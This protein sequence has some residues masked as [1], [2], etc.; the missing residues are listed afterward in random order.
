M[1]VET[2][3]AKASATG[4]SKCIKSTICLVGKQVLDRST[5]KLLDQVLDSDAV[6]E[7]ANL[8]ILQQTIF[9]LNLSAEEDASLTAFF[10]SEAFQAFVQGLGLQQGFSDAQRFTYKQALTN[11]LVAILP[12]TSIASLQVFSQV[13][14]DIL[15]ERAATAWAAA[16]SLGIVEV[17][18]STSAATASY[19]HDNV[20][21]AQQIIDLKLA[22]SSEEMQSVEDF[23][24]RYKRAV[25]HATSRIRPQAPNESP[26]LPVDDLYVDPSVLLVSDQP[27]TNQS[28]NALITISRRSVLLGNPGGGKS[29]LAAKLC[30]D[31]SSASSATDDS[32]LPKFAALVILRDFAQSQKSR[33]SSIA[34]YIEAHCKSEYQIDPPRN[35]FRLL[36]LS[37]RI[38]IVFDGLDE[39]LE[40]KDRNAVRSAVEHFSIEYPI[41]PILVTSREIGY[42][43]APLDRALFNSFKLTPFAEEQVKQYAEKWFTY[44]CSP[45][46][47]EAKRLSLA[48]LRDSEVVP[49][50]RSNPLMLGLLCNLYKQDGFIPRNRPEVYQRC[51][52]LLFMKWDSGRG[53]YVKLPLD[54]RLRPAMSYLAH[55]I[56]QDETLQAGVTEDKLVEATSSYLSQWIEDED[57]A[58]SISRQ[59]VE[60]FNGRA[61][62]FTD[63]GSDRHQRL[64]Q[65]THRTFLEYFTA[66]RL[67][68][69]F[70]SPEQLYENLIVKIESRDWDVVC[71]L[72]F[73]LKAQKA[74]AHNEFIDLL[75]GRA[76]DAD[77]PKKM[78]ILSFLS[79]TLDLLYPMPAAR[80]KAVRM[81]AETLFSNLG[82]LQDEFTEF[83][84]Q[85]LEIASG[86]MSTSEESLKINSAELSEA[87]ARS[88]EDGAGT[89]VNDMY[90]LMLAED[91]GALYQMAVNEGLQSADRIR[92]WRLQSSQLSSLTEPRTRSM[93]EHSSEMAIFS[94]WAGIFTVR[95]IVQSYGY[96]SLFRAINYP[97]ASWFRTPISRGI[98]DWTISSDVFANEGDL[99]QFIRLKKR[100]FDECK[101]ISDLY[102]VAPSW[103]RNQEDFFALS[104]SHRLQNLQSR[105]KLAWP[106]E[107][108]ACEAFLICMAVISEY[109]GEKLGV[110]KSGEVF[111][112][113]Q[114]FVN[115]RKHS[116]ELR[117]RAREV[118]R[119]RCAHPLVVARLEE[120]V[121]GQKNFLV[122]N[123]I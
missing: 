113:L 24:A 25:V 64:Y 38:L 60:F 77:F 28:S 112:D 14:F 12:N 114:A 121:S 67:V 40:I 89:S 35:A 93:G 97:L 34:D 8:S 102:S 22:A 122:T 3:L 84:P 75:C 105:D 111:D 11:F 19:V 79:R 69:L 91:L 27:A 88:L 59:F 107:A 1:I 56:Y 95:E 47:E 55:W 119:A 57:E 81:C 18:W 36:L 82:K 76:S 65:F 5:R 96:D 100:V 66:D 26:V 30:H 68:M 21:S 104:I 118:V 117:E 71:Q 62:V 43:Q 70:G 50:L 74:E 45:N 58:K 99:E 39:L 41:A 54:H 98:T 103:P 120:W 86:I 52:D 44:A 94:W 13:I 80:R 87:L 9:A 29:T 2:A 85:A 115:S 48:F 123:Q 72:A 31:I 108:Y 61:W 109:T 16:L 63:T 46:L 110:E 90:V 49:D 15:C 101:T 83:R 32:E 4:L 42:E 116:V 7:L 92:F 33:Q 106:S 51:A 20:A 23:A 37:G 10:T 6:G 73:Q 53:I 17:G 78:N